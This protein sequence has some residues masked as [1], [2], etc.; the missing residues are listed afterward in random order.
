MTAAMPR[1]DLSQLSLADGRVTSGPFGPGPP[2]A[3]YLSRLGSAESR[4]AMRSSLHT[5]RPQP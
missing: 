3:A 1:F 5:I 2:L 4:R